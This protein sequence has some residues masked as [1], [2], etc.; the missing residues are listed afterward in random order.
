MKSQPFLQYP[1]HFVSQDLCTFESSTYLVTTDH[2]SDFTGVDKL[3]NTLSATILA[4]TEA[5]FAHHT[6]KPDKPRHELTLLAQGKWKVRG[7]SENCQAHLAKVW[8]KWPT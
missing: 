7:V 1:W 4:K 2:Y 6:E 3:E 5:N 8:E